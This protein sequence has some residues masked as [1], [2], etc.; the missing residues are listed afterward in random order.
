MIH[1]PV[2]DLIDDLLSGQ[3]SSLSFDRLRLIG[4]CT[5]IAVR[6]IFY[7]RPDTM[8]Q[9]IVFKVFKLVVHLGV[10]VRFSFINIIQLVQDDIKG[11]FQAVEMNDLFSVLAGAF[12]PEISIDEQKR[13]NRQILE[14]Q[15]PGRMIRCDMCDNRQ[16]VP[17][18]TV[19]GIVI[20]QIRD[21][22]F[23]MFPAAVFA[24][25]MGG[26]RSG[27]QSQIDRNPGIVK[28]SG[29]I[30]GNIVNSADMSECIERCDVRSDPHE[31]ID[32]K[33]SD[34]L[35]QLDVTGDKSAISD[36][37][38]RKDKHVFCRIKGT[39]LTFVSVDSAEKLQ[40]T[41][42]VSRIIAGIRLRIQCQGQMR[43][44]LIAQIKVGVHEPSVRRF[45]GSLSA[46]L[47]YVFLPDIQNILRLESPVCISQIQKLSGSLRISSGQLPAERVTL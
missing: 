8:L 28:L 9:H 15:I 7:F 17:V 30:H 14:F 35:L 29:C 16:F 47:L 26:C 11:F 24:N 19:I 10:S 37:C 2:F 36:L 46:G 27:Y 13:F 21:A 41:V 3:E 1:R 40:K 4:T 23:L 42:P 34:Q 32:I 18:Q 22:V 45:S 38:V 39:D 12:C 5:R 20:V 44:Q 31:F 6:A 43:E 33:T 25:V